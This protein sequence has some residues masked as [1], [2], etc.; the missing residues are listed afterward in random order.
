[1]AREGVEVAVVLIF[2]RGV[3]LQVQGVTGVCA[4]AP[5]EPADDGPFSFFEVVDSCDGLDHS[6]GGVVREGWC[7]GR[8]GRRNVRR[9][10]LIVEPI[11]HSSNDVRQDPVLA[12]PVVAHLLL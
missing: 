10:G 5:P 4:D 7:V 8:L 9:H 3:K 12:C 1:M 2:Q 6:R 11:S